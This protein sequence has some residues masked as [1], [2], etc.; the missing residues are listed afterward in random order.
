MD[1]RILINNVNLGLRSA[2]IIETEKGYIFE[3]E[4]I[5]EMYFIVGGGIEIN[6][7]SEDAAKREIY[8]ELGIKIDNISLKAI[9]ERFFTQ[10]DKKYHEIGFYY[11]CK[12]EGEI[13]LPNNFFILDFEEMKSKDV[14]PKIISDI[15]KDKKKDIIHLIIDK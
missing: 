9:I 15:I 3:K 12:L 6:E 7:S 13:N 5:K 4:P 11:T 2:V 10:D 1:L 8:E 14:K